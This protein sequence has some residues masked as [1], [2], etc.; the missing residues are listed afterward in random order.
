MATAG[1]SITISGRRIWRR[2]YRDEVRDGGWADHLGEREGGG[3]GRVWLGLR[4]VAW[5]AD[6]IRKREM[7]EFSASGGW[8]LGAGEFDDRG[9]VGLWGDD[10]GL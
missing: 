10:G 6:P 9:G 1:A 8:G 3:D 4:G 5:W 2:V 7:R